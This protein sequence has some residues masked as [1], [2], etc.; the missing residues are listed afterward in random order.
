MDDFLRCPEN[1]FF[2]WL[3][4]PLVHSIAHPV[5][6]LPSKGIA[7]HMAANNS[8]IIKATDPRRAGAPRHQSL[9]AGLHGTCQYW[10]VFC[11]DLW[12]Q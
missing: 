6:M 2:G 4:A 12:H 3:G 1:R 8:N 9:R 5:N 7:L 10:L 11:M